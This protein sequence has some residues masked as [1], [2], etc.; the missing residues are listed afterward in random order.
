M[1]GEASFDQKSGL[2]LSDEATQAKA[3][4]KLLQARQG[5]MQIEGEGSDPYLARLFRTMDDQTLQ[6]ITDA[7]QTWLL[8][9]MQMN[10]AAENEE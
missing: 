7:A 8:P 10:R 2:L 4:I 5:N 1:H 6:V 9:L 3:R